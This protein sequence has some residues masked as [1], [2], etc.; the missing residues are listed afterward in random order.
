MTPDHP[1][2]GEDREDGT[3]EEDPQEQVL[4]PPEQHEWFKHLDA[5]WSRTVWW[6]DREKAYKPRNPA[7]PIVWLRTPDRKPETVEE[8]EAR[9]KN[10]YRLEHNKVKVGG[11][12]WR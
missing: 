2:R 11:I 10:G 12:C 3:R 7:K 5:R 9:C 1:A 6:C 8:A 4:P